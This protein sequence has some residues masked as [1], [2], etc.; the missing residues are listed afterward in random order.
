MEKQFLRGNLVSL[1]LNAVE[2][3]AGQIQMTYVLFLHTFA[4]DVT[5]KIH[6]NKT[7][8]FYDQ[9]QMRLALTAK[10]W[11]DFVFCTSNGLVIEFFMIKNKGV[12]RKNQ[13]KIFI[14]ITCQ[15][16]QLQHKITYILT[17]K[18]I[19]KMLPL[20]KRVSN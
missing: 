18:Q 15:M 8:T 3:I 11:C 20:L 4:F 1:K 19:L 9:I 6:I 12:N 17:H 2:N 16:K 14:F 10:I 13:F 5:E 7:H